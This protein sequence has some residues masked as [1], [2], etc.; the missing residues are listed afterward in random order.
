MSIKKLAVVANEKEYQNNRQKI[1]SAYLPLE[2]K[3]FAASLHHEQ[4][5]PGDVGMAIPD[6]MVRLEKRCHL[7][8]CRQLLIE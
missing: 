2:I 1:F 6:S 3:V 8:G 4:H 7:T 5:E